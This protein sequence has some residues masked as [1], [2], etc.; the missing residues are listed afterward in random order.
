MLVWW[1]QCWDVL[2]PLVSLSHT[3]QLDEL[4]NGAVWV[5]GFTTDPRPVSD[6]Y[7]ESLSLSLS[8]MCVCECVCLSDMMGASRKLRRAVRPHHRPSDCE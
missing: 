1:R 7:V 5:A 3:P 8:V 4:R 2:W 6:L